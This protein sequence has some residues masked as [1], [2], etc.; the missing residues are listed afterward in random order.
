VTLD[1]EFDNFASF[2][3]QSPRFWSQLELILT[4]HKLHQK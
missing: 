2:D 3:L 1:L 4:A